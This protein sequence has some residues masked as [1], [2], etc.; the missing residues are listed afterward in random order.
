MTALSGGKLQLELGLK[1]RLLRAARSVK[2]VFELQ[3]IAVDRMD[4]L[5]SKLKDQQEELDKLRNRGKFLY[6]ES[7]QWESSS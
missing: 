7:D 2:Y 5:E 3:P 1:I 4:I 6:V